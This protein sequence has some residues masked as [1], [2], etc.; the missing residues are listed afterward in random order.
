MQPDIAPTRR[1]VVAIIQARNVVATPAWE[2]P[3]ANRIVHGFRKAAS[4]NSPG[5]HSLLD[6]SRDELRFVRRRVLVEHLSAI[7]QEFVRGPLDDVLRRFSNYTA[8]SG[9]DVIVRLTGDCP[10]HTADT[11]DEVVNAFL[12]VHAD[13]CSNTEPYSTGWFGRR[14]IHARGIRSCGAR[15]RSRTRPRTCH[16]LHAA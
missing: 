10:L 3:S 7:H 15:S 11:V 5:L 12:S 9:A 13:Y 1:K 8:A 2:E 4:A 14:G 6:R 16:A